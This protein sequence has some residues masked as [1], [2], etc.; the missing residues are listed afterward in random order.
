LSNRLDGNN[1][2]IDG[3]KNAQLSIA[4]L[5]ILNGKVY[6]VWDPALIQAVFRNSQLSFLPFATEFAKAELDLSDEMYR[7]LTRTN[8]VPDFFGVIHP[9]L[10]GQHLHS[11]NRNALVYVAS[12]LNDKLAQ[13]EWLEIPNFYLWIRDLMTI[14][15]TEALYGPD[16]VFRDN[17]GL[18][19]DLWYGADSPH[20]GS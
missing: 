14:A 12:Q 11:M 17:P 8:L 1:A 18:L 6:A 2:Q 3:S 20:Q 16:N 15:T 7:I 5:P 4:T 9:A 13:T 10:S 19:N